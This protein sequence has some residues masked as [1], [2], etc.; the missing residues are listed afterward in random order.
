MTVKSAVV[1]VSGSID[2]LNVAATVLLSATLVWRSA[3]LVEVTVGAVVSA[4][5]PVVKVQT[6][7]LASGLPARS[8][9]PVVIVAV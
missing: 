7:L 9:A 3:G 8:L 5:A 6:K 4:V 1:M 2:S